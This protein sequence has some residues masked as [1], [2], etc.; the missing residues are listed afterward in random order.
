MLLLDRELNPGPPEYETGVL[1]IQPSSIILC[2]LS[3][4]GLRSWTTRFWLQTSGNASYQ[5]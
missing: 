1:T 4:L 3:V 2:T 5:Y